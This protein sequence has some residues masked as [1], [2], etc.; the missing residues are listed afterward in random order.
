MT[1]MKQMNK[2]Q[3]KGH[4]QM[5]DGILQFYRNG[6]WGTCCGCPRDTDNKAYPEFCANTERYDH[7]LTAK[8][9]ADCHDRY[10]RDDEN[11]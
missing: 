3:Q 9:L 7:Q 8:E 10:T 2:K 11:D 4:N 5:K 1:K 6:R